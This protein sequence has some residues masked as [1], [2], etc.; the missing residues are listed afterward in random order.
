MFNLLTQSSTIV[1]SVSVSDI[2]VCFTPI[3][4]HFE[5]L[6]KIFSWANKRSNLPWLDVKH[7]EKKKVIVFLLSTSTLLY[8][9]RIQSE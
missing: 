9:V 7:N 2:F 1:F 6:C 4:F 3:L 8:S 5:A